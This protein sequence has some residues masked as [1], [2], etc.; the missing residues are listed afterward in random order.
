[1]PARPERRVR[2]NKSKGKMQTEFLHPLRLQPGGAGV[3]VSPGF[4]TDHEKKQC[5]KY[6][7]QRGGAES[8]S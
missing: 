3:P 2:E 7:D 5:K 4:G 1:M 8:F 6:P